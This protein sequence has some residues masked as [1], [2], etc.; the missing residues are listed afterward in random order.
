[1]P[2]IAAQTV[3]ATTPPLV[4]TRTPMERAAAILDKATPVIP[5]A[6]IPVVAAALETAAANAG[7]TDKPSTET[8]A[9]AVPA[10]AT[11]IAEAAPAEPEA[12]TEPQTPEQERVARAFA[13]LHKREQKVV[14]KEQGAAAREKLL[15]DRERALENRA[16]AIESELL[17][18][19]EAPAKEFEALTAELSSAKAN[20]GALLRR[21]WGDEW[22]KTLT[23]YNL[24]GETAT[25]AMIREE[26]AQTRA[27]IADEIESRIAKERETREAAETQRN[28]AEKSRLEA[29]YTQAIETQR[30]VVRQHV[31]A[32]HEKYPLTVAWGR[33]QT[34]AE[35]IEQHYSRTVEVDAQGNITKPGRLL[36]VDEAAKLVEDALIADA[37]KADAIR[38]KAA[39]PKAPASKASSGA[40][41]ITPGLSNGLAASQAARE[42]AFKKLPALERARLIMEKGTPEAAMASM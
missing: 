27:E 28:Q 13:Q 24:N 10:A 42:A 8:P 33:E 23:E 39:T 36:S 40:S 34:V 38:K 17:K 25:P 21:V 3:P 16:K 26:L 14:A 41:P 19:Y 32:N 12:K 7:V 9:D 6:Q 29:E 30:E 11:E 31:V 37:D 15:L 18:K 2:D 4:D 22:Y 5:A 35:V 1:M 20:P